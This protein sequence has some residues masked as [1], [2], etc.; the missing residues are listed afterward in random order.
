MTPWINANGIAGVLTAL[1]AMRYRVWRSPKTLILYFGFFFGVE[2]AVSH[3]LLPPDA[4]GPEVGIVCLCVG[5]L[6]CAAI[7]GIDKV[8]KA[9]GEDG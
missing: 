7:Y 3:W 1:F 2:L 8:E 4:F 9:S 6:V 5:V